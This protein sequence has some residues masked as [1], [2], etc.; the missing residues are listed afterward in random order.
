MVKVMNVNRITT[1]AD[2][3]LFRSSLPFKTFEERK[4][5]KPNT[6][7][8]KIM[9]ICMGHEPDLAAAFKEEN[10]NYK[11]DIKIC[12]ILTDKKELIFKRESEAD[13]VFKNNKI[14]I[15][16]FYPLNLLQKLSIDK[17]EVD[18]YKQLVE[19]VMIDYNYDGETLKP[20]I[21]DIPEKNEFVKGI[22]DIPENHGRI[23]IKITDL[24]SES[25]EMEV[26]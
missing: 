6:P 10:L 21:T 24:L 9:I 25:F 11:L 4:Q 8:E 18:E 22:Y 13:I 26:K 15:K 23:K 1:K 2:L 19:S 16:N 14:K 7:V 20:Q 12:D 17:T 3:E 5:E